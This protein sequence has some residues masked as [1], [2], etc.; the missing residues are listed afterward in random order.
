MVS[1]SQQSKLPLPITSCAL[2][3][4]LCSFNHCAP[5][6]HR[7]QCVRHR[8][9]QNLSTKPQRAFQFAHATVVLQ[10]TSLQV[11]VVAGILI[12]VDVYHE[13]LAYVLWPRSRTVINGA[14]L[15][16]ASINL[17]LLIKTDVIQLKTDG[18]WRRIPSNDEFRPG[19]QPK[20]GHQDF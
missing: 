1:I 10:P 3:L 4:G 20:G 8:C 12:I 17:Q 7:Q 13:H 14:R 5:P 16:P 2:A 6:R 18:I 9:S 19:F 11:A 15:P